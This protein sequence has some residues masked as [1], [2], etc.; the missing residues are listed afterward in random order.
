MTLTLEDFMGGGEGRAP[1]D[2][3]I[4]LGVGRVLSYR[5]TGGTTNIDLKDPNGDEFR[6]VGYPYYVVINLSGSNNLAMRDESAAT[7]FTLTP[8]QIGKIGMYEEADGTRHWFGAVY[9]RAT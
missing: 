4:G 3:T 5:P 2:I 1:G 7:I 8:N 6:T 9:T